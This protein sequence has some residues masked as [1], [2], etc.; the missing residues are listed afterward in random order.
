MVSLLTIL[1]IRAYTFSP[2]FYLISSGRNELLA[3]YPKGPRR[4]LP[5]PMLPPFTGIL[6]PTP[7]SFSTNSRAVFMCF[8]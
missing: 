6:T 1:R 5:F 7:I 4:P 2:I 8:V 3:F